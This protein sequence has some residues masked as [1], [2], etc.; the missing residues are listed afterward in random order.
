MRKVIENNEIFCSVVMPVHNGERFL[1]EAIESVLNQTY[2]NFEFLI[3]ENC[4]NDSSVEIIKSYKDE[5]IRLIIEEDCGIVQ[6]YNRGFKEAKGEYIVV[7]DHDDVSF[8]NRIKSQLEY[9]IS[10]QIDLCGSSFII[11]NDRGEEIRKI[12]PPLKK[13]KIVE[14]ILFDFF[15]LF[16]PT[17]IL[18][19]SLLEK[20]NFFDIKKPI[21]SDYDFILKSINGFECGNN[22]ELLLKYRVHKNSTSKKND[23][24]ISVKY[25]FEISL[26]YFAL[27]K[28]M[29][30]DPDFILSKINYY[31]RKNFKATSLMIR[32]ILVKGIKKEKI[33]YLSYT[34]ILALPL[35][36]LRGMDLFFNKRFNQ[37][38]DFFRKKDYSK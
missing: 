9:I 27:Y 34:T 28:S 6:G 20:L 17:L 30:S 13:E 36:L 14:R 10:N 4:S 33:K 26:H 5:R 31:Y 23:K 32:S 18:K 25:D 21:G 16:N 2:T 19:K 12:Y 7:H 35:Y 15:A 8:S 22:P 3:I 38:L 11:I 24:T 29:Y 1:R 37:F